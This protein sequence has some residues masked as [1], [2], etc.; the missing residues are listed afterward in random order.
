MIIIE[1]SN[2]DVV[3]EAAGAAP[4][5]HVLRR[6]DDLPAD[7][8]AETQPRPTSESRSVR[9]SREQCIDR[10]AVVSDSARLAADVRIGPF[11]VVEDDVVVGRGSVLRAHCILRRGTTVGDCVVVDSF[12]VIGGDPQDR[13]FDPDTPS[14]V[15]LEDRVTVREAV[16][17]HRST[18]AGGVTRIGAGALLMA[19]SHV[20]HDCRVG[21]DAVLA[22]NVMLGG[23]VEVGAGAFVGG[24]VGVHQ[25]VRIG[26]G[27]MIGGN[28]SIAYD[29]A[30]FTMA[31]GR[32]II[33]GLNV[34]GLRRRRAPLVEIDDLKR[35]F[36]AVFARAGDPRR[37]AAAALVAGTCGI[38]ALG[39]ALLEFFTAG[40]R[41]FARPRSRA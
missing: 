25:H 10:T 1:P 20:G 36:R 34:V 40:V 17:V 14:G 41:G 24:G 28:A 7:V 33:H 26:D 6:S 38:S 39:R 11:A 32:S 37:N 2:F 16:T 8:G 4:D 35:C 3:G 12:A 13:S 5:Q 22:N 19:N 18:A 15:V 29:V 30:P 31:S 21:K 27:A 9:T 23:H